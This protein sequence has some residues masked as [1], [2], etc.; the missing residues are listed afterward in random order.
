M[1]GCAVIYVT[2]IL[3]NENIT[4][5]WLGINGHDE[6]PPLAVQWLKLCLPV[7]GHGFN[8]CLGN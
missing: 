2:V 3:I 6:G 4:H 1:G 7:Q 8:L 5:V